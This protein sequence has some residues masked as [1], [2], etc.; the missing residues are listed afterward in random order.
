MAGQLK[1]KDISNIYF[2]G[3]SCSSTENC[4]IVSNAINEFLPD[5]NVAVDHDVMAAAVGLFGKGKGMACILG[6]GSNSCFYDG[7][8]LIQN[9]PSLGHILGDEGSGTRLGMRRLRDYMYKMIPAHLNTILKEKGLDKEFILNK[10]YKEPGGNRWLASF[11]MLI[12]ENIRDEYCL[13]IVKDNFR[14]FFKYHVCTFSEYKQ[15]PLGIVGSIGY[16]FSDILKEVAKEF[17]YEID[18]I[19]QSPMDGLKEFHSSAA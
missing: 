1:G 11:A 7:K 19:I 17:G 4:D 10:V 3:A 6:T 8:S 13:E 15:Y 2:Y 18:K 14:D 9:V 5:I 16:Y 12:K